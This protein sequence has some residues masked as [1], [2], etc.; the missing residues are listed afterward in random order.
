MSI[1]LLGESTHGHIDARDFAAGKV[2]THCHQRKD[3][4][5]F[6][7]KGCD[8]LGIQRYQSTCKKCANKS[9]VERYKRKFA[10]KMHILR[11]HKFDLSQCQIE[12]VYEPSSKINEVMRDYVEA[13]YATTRRVLEQKD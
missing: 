2:C 6:H 1:M 8:K 7:L 13:I 11:S 9:R 10:K 5:L 4:S 3:L 12:I